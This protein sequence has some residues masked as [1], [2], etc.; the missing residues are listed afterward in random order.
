[1]PEAS[2]TAHSGRAYQS[3]GRLCSA[4]A[5]APAC[6]VQKGCQR[7]WSLCRRRPPCRP[8]APA[9]AYRA[10]SRTCMGKGSGISDLKRRPT[11]ASEVMTGR[12]VSGLAYPWKCCTS[13]EPVRRALRRRGADLGHCQGGHFHHTVALVRRGPVELE[14]A[15][16][17]R[18]ETSHHGPGGERLA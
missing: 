18:H 2:A 11:R 1:M 7:L 8:T 16:V 14:R 13:Q 6:A 12:L 3:A 10:P 4:P 9:E 15:L 17:A 5:L